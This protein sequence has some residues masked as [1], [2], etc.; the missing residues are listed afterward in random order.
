M[1]V[2]ELPEARAPTRSGGCKTNVFLPFVDSKMEQNGIEHNKQNGVDYKGTNASIEDA[3][4]MTP[5]NKRKEKI[6]IT[7][8]VIIISGGFLFLFTAFQSLQNLQSSLN[9]TEGRT[10]HWSKSAV[11]SF[12]NG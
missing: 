6:Y 2:S 5:E 7:K 10:G 4:S 1:C 8:N 12:K 11:T 9:A 3:D